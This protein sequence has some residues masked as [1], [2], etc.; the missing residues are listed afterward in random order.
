V[1]STPS[2]MPATGARQ[3]VR[4]FAMSGQLPVSEARMPSCDHADH[5]YRVLHR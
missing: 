2:R 4:A 1:A 5:R 3:S